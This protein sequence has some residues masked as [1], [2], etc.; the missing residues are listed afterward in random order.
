M[1]NP[2]EIPF[3]SLQFYATAPYPCSY[4]PDR[5][6]RS[7]VATPAQLIN[8]ALYDQLINMGFRRSG[9]FT[10][11]PY[12]DNC[13][14]CIATRIPVNS[15]K[16]SRSQQRAWRKY[17]AMDIHILPLDFSN[18]HFELYQHYQESRHADTNELEDKNND[19]EYNKDQYRQFLLQTNI[20]SI[21]VEFRE[22]GVLRMVSIIDVLKDGLSSVYTFYD[23]QIASSSFGTFSI[24]WQIEQAKMLKLNYVYLGYYIEQ[25]QKMSYKSLYRP[26]EGLVNNQWSTIFN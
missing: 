19:V 15:F 26:L 17:Q 20:E 25:S 13:Q 1:S 10:Y 22:N 21:L 3:Q 11:R 18:E 5:S 9:L 6:A 4:L 2:K 23:T 7:Q 14:A 24:L 8:S 16:A 12:C